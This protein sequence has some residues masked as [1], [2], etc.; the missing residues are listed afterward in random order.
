MHHLQTGTVF[1]LTVRSVSL[2]SSELMQRLAFIRPVSER[3]GV[4]VVLS[5]EASDGIA[6][7]KVPPQ[8]EFYGGHL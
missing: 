2:R 7:G 1:K 8:T 4:E 5:L 3:R 6:L